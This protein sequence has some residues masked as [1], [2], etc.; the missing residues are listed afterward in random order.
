MSAAPSRAEMLVSRCNRSYL[1]GALAALMTLSGGNVAHADDAA[2]KAAAAALQAKYVELGRQLENNPFQKPLYLESS[3]AS[4]ELKSNVY[5]V[6]GHPFAVVRAELK[7]PARWCDILILHPNTKYCRPSAAGT[8]LKVNIGRK[9]DQPIEKSFRVDFDY[10]VREAGANYLAVVLNA[11]KGPMGTR[12]YRLLLEAVP[13]EDGRT[14]MH[15][16]YSYGYGTAAKLALLAY[17]NTTG[18]KKV[19]FTET[20][21]H[22]D[23]QPVYIDGLRGLIERNTMRYYL[24]IEAYLGSLSAPP[25]AQLEKRIWDWYSASERYPLQLHDIPQGEY[26]ALKRKEHQRQQSDL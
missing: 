4:G 3:Q 23:G 22:K 14:F 17:L 19:G 25:L 12:D 16:A 26:L 8:M 9:S 11:D 6:L 5:A 7:Q 15:L 10:S 18:S 13:L 1:A 24:A 21:R 2:T 20:G